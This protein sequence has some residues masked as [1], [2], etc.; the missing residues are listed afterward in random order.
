MCVATAVL[1]LAGVYSGASTPSLSSNKPRWE[2]SKVPWLGALQAPA[3]L[4]ELQAL[5]DTDLRAKE[6]DTP[7]AFATEFGPNS[8]LSAN[9]DGWSALGLLN[10]GALDP[11]GCAAA[12]LTCTVLQ[13][14]GKHLAPRVG[15][16][17][18][19]V[20]LLKLAAGA[21]LR[22]HTG[23]G[24]RLVAHLGLR[25]PEHGATL[26]VAGEEIN[27]VEGGLTIFDDAFLHSARNKGA[28]ARYVLHVTF[29]LP[30]DP[31][32]ATS[33]GGGASVIQ[34]TTTPHAKLEISSDCTVTVTNL[35]NNIAS[36]PEPLALLYNKV[37]TLTNTYTN[38][39]HDLPLILNLILHGAGCGRARYQHGAVHHR[40][41][42]Q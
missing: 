21:S 31:I 30:T 32:T 20:R 6:G 26:T 10:K 23:P 36:L 12:P 22:P 4:T 24:G 33:N 35:R 15:A 39:P 41:Y 9:P 19:G 25:V 5:A 2:L 34:T 18:V 28:T 37:P 27:W 3:V 40:H 38:S 16:E 7:T 42:G 8:G 17:E 14:L 13:G 29:P 11:A 1:F